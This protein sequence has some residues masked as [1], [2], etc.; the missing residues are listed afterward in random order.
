MHVLGNDQFLHAVERML[1][2]GQEVRND[3]GHP[4]AVVENAIGDRAHQSDGAAA[5][6]K[7]DACLGKTFAEGARRLHELGVC[8]GAGTAI[9]ADCLNN[10]VLGHRL[11]VALPRD[12]VKTSRGFT[13]RLSC[14]ALERQKN[15]LG[16]VRN[17]LWHPI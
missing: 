3:A 5:I 1:A 11:D 6:N 2:R 10:I 14:R 4:A 7:A 15:R 16:R 13:K 12:I 9:N 17:S 8:T